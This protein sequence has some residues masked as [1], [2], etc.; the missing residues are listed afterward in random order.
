MTTTRGGG[1]LPLLRGLLGYSIHC[2]RREARGAFDTP[3]LRSLPCVQKRRGGTA[4]QPHHPLLYRHRLLDSQGSMARSY[5]S[6][7]YGQQQMA[8]QRPLRRAVPHDAM[9]RGGGAVGA[10]GAAEA[11][12]NLSRMVATKT[13]WQRG[14]PG[15]RTVTAD[16]G[17]A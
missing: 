1:E 15:L 10:G 17:V 14:G 4:V 6:R 9:A 12:P 5:Q 2:R 8:R 13:W 3:L 16:V 7:S 11:R